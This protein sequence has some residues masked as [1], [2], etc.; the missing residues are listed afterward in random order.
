MLEVL[1]NYNEAQMKSN[2]LHIKVTSNYQ[3]KQVVKEY[4]SVYQNI[5]E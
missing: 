1:S 2:K 3:I 5:I 4:E